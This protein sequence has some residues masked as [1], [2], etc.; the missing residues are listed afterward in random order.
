MAAFPL[1]CSLGESKVGSVAPG[2]KAWHKTPGGRTGVHGGLI[3]KQ[4]STQ[5]TEHKAWSVFASDGL[6]FLGPGMPTW[7]AEAVE[8]RALH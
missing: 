2:R 7:K 1:D 4:S 5:I 3:G 8:H 6:T